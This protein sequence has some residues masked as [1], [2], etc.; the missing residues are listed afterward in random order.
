M[1]NVICQLEQK[2]S[3]S[4]TAGKWS[5]SS[6]S[7]SL[8]AS[9]LS[10]A[11]P[12][13]LLPP[14]PPS[15]LC[16]RAKCCFHVASACRALKALDPWRFGHIGRESEGCGFDASGNQ[17]ETGT[18]PGPGGANHS[19]FTASK[20]LMYLTNGKKFLW[21]WVETTNSVG[22]SKEFQ[23]Q[24]WRKTFNKPNCNIC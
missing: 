9:H 12:V 2:S 6:D 11:L 22:S 18:H 5:G 3:L 14:P 24:W 13:L 16:E 8:H 21:R 15:P 10:A 17:A 4:E 20:R 1:I 19:I 23:V 7:L